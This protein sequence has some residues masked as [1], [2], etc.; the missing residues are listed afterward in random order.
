M[1][2]MPTKKLPPDAIEWFRKQGA[3]G[4]KIGGSLGGKASAAK[5]TAAQ[6]SARAKHAVAAREAKRA[7]RKRSSSAR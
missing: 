1:I 3:L 7:L 4:G 2:R 6:R 5:L